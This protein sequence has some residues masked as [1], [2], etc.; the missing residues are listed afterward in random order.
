MRGLFRT[1]AAVTGGLWIAY[2]AVRLA[3]PAYWAPVTPVDHLA[4]VLFS[5][6]MLS[7]ALSLWPLGTSLPG[8]LSARAASAA[9]VTN[10]VANFLE[11]WIGLREFGGVWVLSA[12]AFALALG[13]LAVSQIWSATRVY[14]LV[15]A[16]TVL[17][18]VFIERGGA[19]LIGAVWLAVAAGWPPGIWK[20]G[21]VAVE[22][23]PRSS[24]AVRPK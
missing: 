10:G 12:G 5:A 7:L 8:R 18:L 3:G 15:A 11:D 19:A 9:A 20:R 1:V 14:A 22:V 2:A 13:A 24:A 16:L 21:T 17:G 6:A 4:V 23:M